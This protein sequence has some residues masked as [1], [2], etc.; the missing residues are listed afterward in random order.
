MLS[1]LELTAFKA[2]DE[3]RLPL[4]SLTLL[5]GINSA[6]K[7]TVLQALAL[8]RQSFDAAMLDQLDRSE[9]LLNGPLVELGTIGDI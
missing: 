9:L 1:S 3:L 8:V 2:F 6:G 4:G 5:S 7:S